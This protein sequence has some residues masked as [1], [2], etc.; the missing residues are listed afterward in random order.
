MDHIQPLPRSQGRRIFYA[1]STA[2]LVASNTT[3]ATGL[4]G[5][6]GLAVWE[7]TEERD[8]YWDPGPGEYYKASL[9]ALCQW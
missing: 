5:L 1:C 6:T 8:D 9:S 2:V 3:V 4:T 7:T